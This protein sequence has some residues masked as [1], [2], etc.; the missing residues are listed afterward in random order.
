MDDLLELV[1]SLIDD[2]TGNQLDYAIGR[3]A[4]K[5]TRN[6]KNKRAKQ[7]V[8]VF[9]W[10]LVILLVCAVVLAIALFIEAGK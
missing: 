4:A 1:L 2:L 7:I 10:A 8:Y 5:L 6:I 3:L 9:V